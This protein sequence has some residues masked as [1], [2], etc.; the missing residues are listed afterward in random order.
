MHA[1][2]VLAA[3][4]AWSAP[5]TV[6]APHTFAGPLYA[7]SALVAWGWQDGV[8]DNVTTGAS[9]ASIAA[10]AVAAPRAAPAGLVAAQSHQGGAV[11]LANRQLD[12]RGRRWRL[13]VTD[14]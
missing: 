10:G 11:L 5:Q 14:G 9:Q 3:A 8:G 7:D 2:A 1:L 4:A 12:P 6:S 13:T